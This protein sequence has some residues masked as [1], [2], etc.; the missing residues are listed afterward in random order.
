MGKKY[1]FRVSRSVDGE[2]FIGTCRDFPELHYQAA[3]PAGALRGIMEMVDAITEQRK[4][5]EHAAAA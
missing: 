5:K 3:A 1:I 4:Q 2:A